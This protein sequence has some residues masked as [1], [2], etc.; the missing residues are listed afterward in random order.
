QRNQTFNLD[1]NYFNYRCFQSNLLITLEQGIIL[2]FL[3]VCRNI[4]M[5]VTNFHY[6]TRMSSG[7]KVY[8]LEGQPNMRTEDRYRHMTNEKARISPVYPI[9]R[10]HSPDRLITTDDRCG[11]PRRPPLTLTSRQRVFRNLACSIQRLSSLSPNRS[12]NSPLTP[13]SAV[14]TSTWSPNP[15]PDRPISPTL[16]PVY[17]TPPMDEPLALIKKPRRDQDGPNAKAQ[18]VTCSPI[19]VRPSVIT[20][21]SSRTCPPPAI[22]QPPCPCGVASGL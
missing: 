7:F 14:T 16:S 13:S 5:A 11:K 8:I 10:K 12:P 15:S 6:I 1:Q 3:Q 22:L 21:I 20:R 4:K 18:N 2:S 17:S 19:Q 9:K